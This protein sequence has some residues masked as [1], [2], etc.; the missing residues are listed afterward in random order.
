MPRRNSVRYAINSME[1]EGFAFTPDEKIM[2]EKIAAGELPLSA[3]GEDAVEFDRI[4]RK[5][6]PEKY[7]TGDA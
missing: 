5:R 1:M 3:A 2:W 6:F 4:M 7:D